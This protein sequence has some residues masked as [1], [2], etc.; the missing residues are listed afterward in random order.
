MAVI[1][2]NDFVLTGIGTSGGTKQVFAHAQTA[3]IDF[4][5]ALI[6][7]T[8]KSSNSWA[9]F[10]SGR[11]GFTISTDGLIDYA[12]VAT[13][14]NVVT[15]TDMAIQDGSNTGEIFFTITGDTVEGTGNISYQ[16]S[17]RIDSLNQTGGTDD[18]ATWSLSATGNGALTKVIAT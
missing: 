11:K 12:T 3:S 2:G 1:N 7:T 16:G 13:A 17:A 18:V 14:L 4:S 6:E 5:N 8:T 15:L 9:E 10:I